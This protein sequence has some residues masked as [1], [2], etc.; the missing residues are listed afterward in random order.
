MNNKLKPIVDYLNNNFDGDF[1]NAAN[2]FN[3]S[4]RVI[5]KNIDHSQDPQKI[6]NMLDNLFDLVKRLME[7]ER[8][9]RRRFRT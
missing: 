5:N 1:L 3:E 6:K 9:S 8:I 7:C 4:I 2:Y